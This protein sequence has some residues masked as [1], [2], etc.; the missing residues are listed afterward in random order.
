MNE[1]DLINKLLHSKKIMERHQSIPRKKEGVI[2]NYQ[3]QTISESQPRYNVPSELMAESVSKPIPTNN[4]TPTEE[5]I[6]KSKNKKKYKLKPFKKKVR[7][8]FMKIK[9]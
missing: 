6:L 9:N 1:N 5:K 2:N 3:E 8:E 4:E 7:K